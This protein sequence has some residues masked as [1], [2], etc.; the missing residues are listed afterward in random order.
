MDAPLELPAPPVPWLTFE[1]QRALQWRAGDL[2]ISVAA[3][4]GTNWM[5]NIVHQLRSGGED[6]FSD[7]YHVVPW[8]ELVPR[9][10]A[11]TAG[12][13]AALDAMPAEQ[14]RVFKTHSGPPLLPY[15]A[16]GTGPEVKYI[17]VG[18]NPEEALVSLKPFFERHRAEWFALWGMEAGPPLPTFELFYQHVIEPMGSALRPFEH[19]AGWWPH[20]NQA[21]VLVLHFSDLLHDLDGSMRKVAAFTGF[22]P[23]AEQWPGV[24]ERCSFAWMKANQ[25]KFELPE[26]AAVPVLE[27]GSL[28]R[29]GK[30]GEARDEGMTPELAERVAEAGRSILPDDA[31]RWLYEGGELP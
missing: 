13:V 18:R 7:I 11:T 24:V 17:V 5:M 23:S 15:Q 22:E 30:I 27:S 20:R 6:E 29:R 12:L 25:L 8:L 2:V 19:L 21:N 14:R 3:K 16:P 10:G 26:V 4:S 28:I 9:P 1:V 31:L